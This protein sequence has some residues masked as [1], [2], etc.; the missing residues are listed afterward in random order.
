MALVR[1]AATSDAGTGLDRAQNGTDDTA[2]VQYLISMACARK[3]REEATM[4]VTAPDPAA[5]GRTS[6]YVVPATAATVHWGFSAD[7]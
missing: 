6:H 7:L 5:P 3:Q 1:R 4:D 2:L